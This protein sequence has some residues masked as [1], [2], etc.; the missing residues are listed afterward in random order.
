[1]LQILLLCIGLVFVVEGTLYALFPTALKRMIA[2]MGDLSPDSLRTGGLVA[3]VVGALLVW[4]SQ[5]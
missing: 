1:M 2:Q 4:L 3:L 5:L